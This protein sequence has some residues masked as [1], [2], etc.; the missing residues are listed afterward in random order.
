M[1]EDVPRMMA[2]P[3]SEIFAENDRLANVVEDA[4]SGWP[5]QSLTGLPTLLVVDNI[6]ELKTCRF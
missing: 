3:R 6:T 4:V 5:P 1:G 2:P